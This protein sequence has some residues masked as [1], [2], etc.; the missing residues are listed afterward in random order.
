M[1]QVIQNMLRSYSSQ[2]L[3]KQKQR[4]IEIVQLL[5][6]MGLSRSNFFHRVAFYGGS[7]LRILHQLPRFSEDLDFSLVQ[8]DSAFQLE[9]FFPF[10]Q[11]NLSA[12]GFSMVILSKPKKEVSQIQS[13]FLKGN[14]RKHFLEIAPNNHRGKFPF[15]HNDSLKIKF[16]VDIDPPLFANTEVNYLLEPIPFSVKSYD[17]PSLFAGKI[18]AMLCRKWK[19]RIKGRD[20]FDYVWFLTNNVPVNMKHLEARLRQS[21]TLQDGQQWGKSIL[22]KM[23]MDRFETVSYEK[24]KADVMPFI[25]DYTSLELWSSAFFTHITRKSL[26]CDSV[27]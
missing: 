11:D 26:I 9:D 2:D 19:N 24:A 27:H 1:N 21:N 15:S 18:H 4:L 5:T 25:G 8:L 14:T 22:E 10:V 7:S 12:F 16:E 13:A 3:Q 17:L 23:L 6:L 20:Y